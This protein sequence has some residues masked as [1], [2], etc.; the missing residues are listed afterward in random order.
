MEVEGQEIYY[1]W[2]PRYEYKIAQ[3]QI[4]G[5]ERTAVRFISDEQLSETEGYTIPEAFT[6]AEKPL[7]GFWVTKYTGGENVYTPTL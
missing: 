6:F 4:A 1:V 2:I 3:G 5:Q 7:S